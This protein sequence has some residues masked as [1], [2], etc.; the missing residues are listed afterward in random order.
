LL[1]FR[2]FIIYRIATGLRIGHV[3]IGY[4]AL[5]LSMW[6]HTTLLVTEQIY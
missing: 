3:I 2:Y 4:I 6:K 5:Y 1:H